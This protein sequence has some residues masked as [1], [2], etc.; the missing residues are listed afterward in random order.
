MSM[1]TRIR[2]FRPQMQTIISRA[3]NELEATPTPSRRCFTIM[4]WLEERKKEVYPKEEGYDPSLPP[5]MDLE[6][7]AP[8]RL[9]DQLRGEKWA[10]VGLSL[11]EVE[12]EC[13]AVWEG[14]QFGA[15]VDLSK[16]NLDLSHETLVPGVCVYSRRSA[17]LAGWM[18]GLELAN[19]KAMPEEGQLLL[20]TGVSD[21]WQYAT[22]R[23]RNG[24]PDEARA[25]EEAK[26]EASG[27]HFVAVQP[28][29]DSNVADGFWLMRDF[30]PD[31]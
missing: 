10:F 20:E 9:P 4:A 19:L 21:L 27:L 3:C 25:W 14:A 23:P 18:S 13:R 8:E 2:F 29:S 24:A 1:P 12:E 7:K 22:F 28:S 16:L 6:K 17:A 26:Q 15:V 11:A 31:V 30:T 5:P